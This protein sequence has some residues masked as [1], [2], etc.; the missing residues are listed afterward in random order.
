V[1]SRRSVK[2]IHHDISGTTIPG[3]QRI[4]PHTPIPHSSTSRTWNSS[5]HARH[6]LQKVSQ[7][8]LLPHASSE[9]SHSAKCPPPPS[10]SESELANWKYWFALDHLRHHTSHMPGERVC[11]HPHAHGGSMSSA[12]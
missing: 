2:S 7:R 9:S 4:P 5:E 12:I 1:L 3:G 10:A 11:P 8:P 6:A